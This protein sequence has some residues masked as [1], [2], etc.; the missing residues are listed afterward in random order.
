[1]YWRAVGSRNFEPEG[2]YNRSDGVEPHRFSGAC[3]TPRLQ[4]RNIGA[5][6]SG[7]HKETKCET[8]SISM[9][10]GIELTVICV[11]NIFLLSS[12]YTAR[13]RGLGSYFGCERGPD[14]PRYEY[15]AHV[16]GL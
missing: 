4:L 3:V 6:F 1:M 5:R 15:A 12:H 10:I 14:G 2:R 7:R 13:R 11:A 8:V 16:R 9:Y